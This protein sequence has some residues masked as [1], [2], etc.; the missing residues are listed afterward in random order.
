[1]QNLRTENHIALRKANVAYNECVMKNFMP[2]WLAGEKLS[3]TDV[4]TE[5][6]EALQELDDAIF[7]NPLPF[8][9][10]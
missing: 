6:R 3:I 7:E 1:M 4:C 5:E 8:K 9:K 10:F 2:Q